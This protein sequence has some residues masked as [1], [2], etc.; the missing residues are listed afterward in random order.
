[1]G[2]NQVGVL[3]YRSV[4][5][6]IEAPAGKEDG[7]KLAGVEKAFRFALSQCQRVSGTVNPSSVSVVMRRLGRRL[8]FLRHDGRKYTGTKEPTP[9]AR[10]VL[11]IVPSAG[12]TASCM[13]R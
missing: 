7:V 5:Q 2:Q 6:Q 4:G 13:R 1:M 3:R 8:H 12:N 10:A 11:L 9:I